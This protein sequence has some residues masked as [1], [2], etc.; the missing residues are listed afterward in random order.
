[1]FSK[2]WDRYGGNSADISNRASACHVPPIRPFLSHSRE[3]IRT[4]AQLCRRIC[5]SWESLR[6]NHNTSVE[7][8]WLYDTLCL[9]LQL[10]N[11][12][13]EPWLSW[14]SV[15][16]VVYTNHKGS[17]VKNVFCNN[18]SKAALTILWLSKKY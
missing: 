14:T 8:A 9:L 7:G 6:N 3:D 13:E 12:K 15:Q 16:P 4:W 11:G 2:Q 10:A 17:F 18:L 1:M 5:L